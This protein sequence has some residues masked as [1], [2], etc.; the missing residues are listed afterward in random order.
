MLNENLEKYKKVYSELISE[1]AE[2]HNSHLRFMKHVGRDTGFDT[3]KHIVNIYN[4]AHELRRTGVKVCKESMEIKRAEH[5]KAK[6]E[7]RI[8]KGRKKKKI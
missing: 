8:S 7:K 5:F 4:L 1:F 6:E 2:L 3:R